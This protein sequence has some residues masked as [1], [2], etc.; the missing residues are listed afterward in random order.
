MAGS[1]GGGGMRV[2]GADQDQGQGGFTRFFLL[3]LLVIVLLLVIS[4]TSLRTS[5]RATE[6]GK[7]ED[8]KDGIK[9]GA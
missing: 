3:V 9:I 1:L 6:D 4:G 7:T 2:N 8:R 5:S